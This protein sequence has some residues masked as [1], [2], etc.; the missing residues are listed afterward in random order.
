MTDEINE[1]PN[2]IPVAAVPSTPTIKN[3]SIVLPGHL[4]TLFPRTAEQAELN[5]NAGIFLT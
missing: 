3:K 5:L 2:P 4:S 1:V